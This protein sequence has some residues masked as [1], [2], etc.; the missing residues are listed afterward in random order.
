DEAR[1]KRDAA[2]GVVESTTFA[3]KAAEDAEQ[4]AHTRHDDTLERLHESDARMAA[5]AEQLGQLGSNARAARA[6]AERLTA[7]LDEAHERMAIDQE[8]L[9]N[10][11]ERLV[12]AQAEPEQ[13]EADTA[14]AQTQR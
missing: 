5:V 13:T 7:Q 14:S 9:T 10:L 4:Q 2:K 6:E 11:T 8:E 1:V 12:A 3:I